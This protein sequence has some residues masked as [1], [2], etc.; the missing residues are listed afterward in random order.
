MRIVTLIL[1]GVILASCAH[2]SGSPP[3]P[4]S[5]LR[6]GFP[7]IGSKY[8]VLYSFHGRG[9]EESNAGLA[10]INDT[11]YG[12]TY[13]GGINFAGVVFKITTTGA[14]KVI[15]RFKGGNDGDGPSATLINVGGTLYGTTVAGG[16]TGCGGSGCGTVFKIATSGTETVLYRFQGP[17]GDGDDP[18]ARLTFVHGAL[19]GTTL[20]GGAN[21]AGT[22]FGITKTGHE[23]TLYSFQGGSDGGGPEGSL[24]DV[25]GTLLG[26]T[27]YG[28]A[29][30]LG[31]VFGIT[32]SG[33]EMVLHSFTGG[34]GDGANPASGLYNDHGVLYG[35][36]ETGGPGYNGTVFTITPSGTDRVYYGFNGPP[37]GANPT[38]DVIDVNGTLYGTTRSG[39]A[40][41]FGTIFKITA[42]AVE[43][44]VHSFK[45]GDGVDGSEPRDELTYVGD[46]LYGTTNTGGA[47]GDGTVFR[48]TP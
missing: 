21:D 46:R 33:A 25:G 23:A 18:E 4:A 16:G 6:S 28:G 1:C 43:L 36:T 13:R 37:D 39:G 27:F 22:V 31:T 48:A 19:Y 3:L 14:E 7:S 40:H 5:P 35:T 10:K 26:T 34:P 32:P 45:G 9:G 20:Q 8:A 38:A 42:S 17:P 2:T 41:N 47:F 30:N 44:P 24:I 12:V 11:L 29:R 15:Y